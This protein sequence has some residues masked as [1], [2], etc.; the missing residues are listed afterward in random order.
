L[1]ATIRTLWKARAF[2]ASLAVSVL[3][4]SAFAASAL[5]LPARF[6]GVVPQASPTI[7][8]AERLHRGGVDSMRVPLDWGSLQTTR[9]GPIDFSSVDGFV[10]RAARSGIELLPF[11]TGAPQWA[12]PAARVPNGGGSKAPAHLPA[13]GAAATAWSHLLEEL[14]ER[15][16]QYGSFWAEHPAV[17]ERPIRAWQIW[18][19]ENFR[20]FVAHTS[21]AEYGKLVKLSY[22]AIKNVD[23]GAQVILGGLFARPKGSRLPGTKKHKGPD[24]FASD[25]LAAMYKGTPGVKASFNGIAL[26]PYTSRYQEL[27]EE[28]EE[29]RKVLTLNH[30]SAKGLWITEMGWS[31]QPPPA[32]PLENV[33][34]KGPGGQVTQ[35]NGAFH[36]LV[37]NQARWR[38]QRVYWFSVDDTVGTCNFCNGTGLFSTGFKPKKS[39]Y[40]YVKFAGGT[41]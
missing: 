15:Y 21:P 20:Y 29:F 13:T 28:I 16:G 4:L 37:G 19:E 3:L 10:E 17:P 33:F 27:P 12:V 36:L 40:A 18:N 39:W 8:Q 6:W 38:L 7:E 22:I 5:A 23:P 2:A 1:K 30:D 31:S 41:P 9:N 14:V 26:H 11:V 25:F 35:L 24:W 34:A 32:N